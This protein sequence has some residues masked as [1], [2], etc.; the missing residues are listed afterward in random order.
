MSQRSYARHAAP[1]QIE[2][3]E[4][5]RLMAGHVTVRV[6]DG[7]LF[8]RGDGA[9]NS[10]VIDQEFAGPGEL[11]ITA[12]DPETVI[13]DGAAEPFPVAYVP[14]GRRGRVFVDMGGGDDAVLVSEVTLAR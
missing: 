5:R 6:E 11:R 14:L 10:V 13:D 4:Y 12:G 9:G 7:D 8:I 2:S 1:A 3:L